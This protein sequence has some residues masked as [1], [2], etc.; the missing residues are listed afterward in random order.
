MRS[1]VSIGK[2]KQKASV[3]NIHGNSVKNAM[4]TD[5]HPN[6][7]SLVVLVMGG[8]LELHLEQEVPH[9]HIHIYIYICTLCDM[10]SRYF[11][12]FD[13]CLAR[14]ELKLY[15]TLTLTDINP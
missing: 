6:K 15:L 12:A 1:R 14:C 5:Y 10:Y 13:L 2:N 7:L 9:K 4:G 3:R 8:C 11:Q